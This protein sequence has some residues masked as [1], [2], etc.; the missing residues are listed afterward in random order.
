MTRVMASLVPGN[1]FAE[2]PGAIAVEKRGIAAVADALDDRDGDA[3]AAA[4]ASMLHQL[5]ELLIA[6][7]DERGIFAGAAPAVRSAG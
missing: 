3:A 7:L 4:F 5:G 6:R 2:V 1:F